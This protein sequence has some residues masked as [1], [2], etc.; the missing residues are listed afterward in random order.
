MRR[1]SMP[2]ALTPAKCCRVPVMGRR[3]ARALTL[4]E[5]VAALALMAGLLVTVLTARGRLL[6]QAEQAGRHQ[7]AVRALSAVVSADQPLQ[8]KIPAP[9]DGF[10]FHVQDRR[11]PALGSMH[12]LI[13]R[14]SA[15]RQ[16]DPARPALAWV[17]VFVASPPVEQSGESP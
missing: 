15:H 12:L 5:V 7:A 1:S 10:V 11:E 16:D 8:P 4:I 3:G 14:Y 6:G 13:R 2:C 17:E 9:R